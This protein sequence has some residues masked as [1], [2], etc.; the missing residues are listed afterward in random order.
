MGRLAIEL[1][2]HDEGE[3]PVEEFI[4][5][6]PTKV[7]ARVRAHLDHLAEVGNQAAAPISKPLGEGLF[8]LRVGVGRIEVRLL[9]TFFSGR[10]IIILHGFL[11]KTRALPTREVET[12]RARWSELKES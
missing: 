7:R 10:R 12:A 4:N 2:A 9:Y 1:Y 6:L 3:S 5:G 8:E 11:K